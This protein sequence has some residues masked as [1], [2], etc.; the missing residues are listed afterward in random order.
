MTQIKV[1]GTPMCGDCIVAKQ[2]FNEK[3]IEFDFINIADSEEDTKKAIELNNGVRRIPVIVF[4]DSSILVEPSR[5]ELLLKI[6]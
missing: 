2:V 1:Y 5:D 4:E 6:S 3:N